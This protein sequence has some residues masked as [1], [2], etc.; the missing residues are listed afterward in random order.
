MPPMTVKTAQ[1]RVNLANIIENQ[2]GY[3]IH[4]SPSARIN[5]LDSDS[6]SSQGQQ[7]LPDRVGQPERDRTVARL[8][9]DIHRTGP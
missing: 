6:Y 8:R 9:V 7:Q 4:K 1:A 5:N 2:L 3:S